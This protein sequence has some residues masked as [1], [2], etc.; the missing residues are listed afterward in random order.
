MKRLLSVFLCIMLML[1]CV[2]FVSAAPATDAPVMDGKTLVTFGDS[3][4]A[5]STWPR[6]IATAL[7]MHL[8][9]S[10]IGGNT[11]AHALA[12]FERDVAAHDPDFVTMCFG[13]NDF[14]RVNGAPKVDLA[15]YT[16]NMQTLIDKVKALGA[17][18]IL[19]TPPFISEAA[20]GGASNYPEGTVN[21]ALDKYVNAMRTL[22]TD[23]HV[24]LIDIHSVCDNYNVSSFLISDGVHLS[25][26]GNAVYTDTIVAAMTEHFNSDPSAPRVQQPVA[27]KAQAGV[28]TKPIVPQNVDD[29]L[30]IYPDEMAGANNADGSVSFWNKNGLWPEVHYSPALE[31]AVCVPV[32]GSSLTVNVDFEAGSNII[33]FFN[34]PNPTLAYDSTCHFSLTSYLAKALP[35]LKTSY[36]DILGN[37]SVNVTLALEDILPS[38]LIASDGTVLFTGVKVFA[39]GEAGK[40]VT[41]HEMS[42]STTDSAVVPVN[43]VHVDKTSLLPTALSQ[44]SRN[45][46]YAAFGI[47]G[48]TFTLTRDEVDTLMWPSVKVTCNKVISLADTP[49]L[50]LAITMKEGYANGVIN[51]QTMS[52]TTG[53]VQ[54]SQLVNGNEHDLGEATDIYVDLAKYIGSDRTVTITDYTLSVYGEKGASVAWSALAA[55]KIV[56]D[57]I[58]YGDVDGNGEISTVDA[59]RILYH[60]LGSELL[61]ENGVTAADMN[62]D[63]EISTA[64]AREVLLYVVQQ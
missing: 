62:R 24:T 38:H 11:T 63:G 23:N 12:R 1:S 54:I 58:V 28:Y 46:G 13:T 37:Q 14:Y 34:G 64:D 50:H 15:T 52:G 26:Q 18:P 59:R 25:A 44:V 57:A 3:L 53:S 35:T 21:G 29:W 8:V 33:L 51:Y 47:G 10:G 22:A 56:D 45:A 27:P 19:I 7:N 2:S 16:T 40:K 39:V 5:L 9:N 49:L 55:A 4:T 48:G 6:S 20:S 36:D 17:T 61:D 30:I 42:V 60:V 31:D 43:P 32:K 41:I